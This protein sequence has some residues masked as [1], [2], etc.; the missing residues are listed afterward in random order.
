[1]NSLLPVRLPW[2]VTL[3]FT[4]QARVPEKPVA[5]K[6]CCVKSVPDVSCSSM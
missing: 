2:I 1:M 6:V 5:P 3:P 4:S